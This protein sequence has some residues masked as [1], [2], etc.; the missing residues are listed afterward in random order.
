MLINIAQTKVSCRPCGPIKTPLR[1]ELTASCQVVGLVPL[2]ERTKAEGEW[3]HPTLEKT[4]TTTVKGEARDHFQPGKRL[5][6]AVVENCVSQ[7]VRLFLFDE[8]TGW[9]YRPV[10][11][12]R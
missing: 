8:I 2:A 5:N 12:G 1:R 10:V 11:R 9:I 4:G 6:L 7:R 3:K